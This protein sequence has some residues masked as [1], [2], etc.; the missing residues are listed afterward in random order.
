MAAEKCEFREMVC[1]IISK[2]KTLLTVW[3]SGRISASR[4]ALQWCPFQ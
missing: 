4:L 3:D 1:P 2:Q